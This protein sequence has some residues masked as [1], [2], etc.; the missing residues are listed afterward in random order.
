MDDKEIIEMFLAKNEKAIEELDKKYRPLV[1]NIAFNILG[2]EEDAEECINDAYYALWNNI[3]PANPDP[4][5]T[6]LGKIV[7]NI[8]ISR[9]NSNLAKKR[10]SYYDV[11]LEELQDCF[12]A[13]INVE[14][15]AIINSMTASVNSFLRGLKEID[16][17]MF[18]RRYWY[19][20]SIEMIAQEYGMSKNKVAVKLH[21]IRKKL[22]AYLKKEGY[23]V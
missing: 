22:Y 6:Y 8:S 3:P 23:D 10:N 18:V 21:R 16:R 13:D 17:K 4:L 20:E 15:E 19:S 7:R 12:V 14:D 11:A 2:N 9:Y 1:R 5:S